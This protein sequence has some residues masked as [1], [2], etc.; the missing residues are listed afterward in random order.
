MTATE[1]VRHYV[2]MPLEVITAA[3]S[4]ASKAMEHI[5]KVLYMI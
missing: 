2:L 4:K 3:V 5:V 1:K